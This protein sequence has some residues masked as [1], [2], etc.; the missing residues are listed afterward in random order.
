MHGWL[1]IVLLASGCAAGSLAGQDQKFDAAV[2]PPHDGARVFEDA[3]A[4]HDARP[5]DAF[6]PKDAA[7]DAASA[8]F[9]SANTDCTNA[10]ECCIILGSPPGL[11]APGV[12]ILGACIPQ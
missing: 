8:L 2:D 6:V 10:G 4:P 7:P 9:C 11:C 3:P 5:L 12:I 1:A